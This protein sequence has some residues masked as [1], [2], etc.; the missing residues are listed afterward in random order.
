[1]TTLEVLVR[2]QILNELNNFKSFHRSYNYLLSSK[3]MIH[4]VN[5]NYMG[6]I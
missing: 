2:E 5:L 4:A 3:Q 6:T 1:M